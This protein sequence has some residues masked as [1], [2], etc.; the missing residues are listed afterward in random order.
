MAWK[1]EV[2]KLIYENLYK[3]VEGCVLDKHVI[4]VLLHLPMVQLLILSNISN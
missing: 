1:N 3:H 2:L 4:Y